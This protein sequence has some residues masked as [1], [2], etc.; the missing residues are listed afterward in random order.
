MARLSLW[1]DGRHGNDFKFIDKIMSEQFTVGG[2]GILCHKYLGPNTQGIQQATTVAQSSP[3]PVIHL[4]DTTV[5]NIGDVVMGVGIPLNSTVIAKDAATI[6]I[7]ETQF[8]LIAI[9]RG[10]C[11]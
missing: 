7:S 3:G 10:Q 9:H 6:T 1:K 5:I 4:P 2:T 8:D 11:L